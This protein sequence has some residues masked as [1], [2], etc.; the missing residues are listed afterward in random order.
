M[1][2]FTTISTAL[3]FLSLLA[4]LIDIGGGIGLKY[5]VM[6]LLLG[7][8]VLLLLITQVPKGFFVEY[9]L[10]A[11]FVLAFSYAVARGVSQPAVLSEMSFLFFLIF[12]VVGFDIPRRSLTHYFSIITIIGALIIVA[13]FLAILI[14]PPLT[15]VINEI[16]NNY[17]LGYLGI[18]PGS[19]NLPNVYYR[20]SMWLIPGF[21]LLLGRNQYASLLVGIA[22][23][24]TLSAAMA[25]FSLV[26]AVAL[27]IL[28]LHNGL[29]RSKRVYW[30]GLFLILL[31]AVF[32]ITQTNNAQLFTI[33]DKE[34]V[35][36][37]S[38]HSQST[39]IKLGHITG[40]WEAMHASSLNLLLGTGAG[41][42]FYSPGINAT[43]ANVEV[44]HMNVL[45]QYG[46]IGAAIFFGYIGYVIYKVYKTDCT[47]KRWAI[48]L[49]VLF[50]AAGTNPLLMSPVFMVPLMAARAYGFR[51]RIEEKNVYDA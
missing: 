31:V 10:I 50:L 29:L 23:V 36:K 6:F 22:I 27:L 12:L 24:L 15:K 32:W 20:W 19:A 21:I 51:F 42:A 44:S 35:A 49:S 30:A 47:G 48:G 33:I 45:R 7:W 9:V 43:T 28:S 40:S 39:S 16:G 14:F 2:R 3:Y 25:L 8:V 17:R 41:S 37:F 18:T 4:L 11:L 1:I 46:I 26:G 13:T 34:F 38:S 5:A